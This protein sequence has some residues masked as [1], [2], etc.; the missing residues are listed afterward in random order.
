MFST[1]AFA[2]AAAPASAGGISVFLVQMAPLLFLF[3]IFW[4]L[5]IRPQQ[6]R[7]KQHRAMVDA[8]KRGDDVVTGGGL[9][10][11]V[12]KVDGDTVEVEL[13]PSVKV[14]VVKSTLSSV[15]VRGSA[16]PA[17]DTKA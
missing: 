10:G 14:K 4:F 9:L 1:P 11:R 16:T 5:I 17:N 15:T 2:Q 12:A 7:A 3:V 6:Q 13:A 8:V